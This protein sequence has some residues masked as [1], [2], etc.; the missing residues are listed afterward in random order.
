MDAASF[1]TQTS[2]TPDMPV[3]AREEL[4]VFFTGF[5][6]H[7]QVSHVIATSSK[8]GDSSARSTT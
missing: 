4:D 8:P 6:V 3:H 2:S 7:R 5:E 1:Q